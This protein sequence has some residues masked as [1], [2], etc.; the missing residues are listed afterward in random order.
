MIAAQQPYQVWIE[1][2]AKRPP[3]QNGVAVLQTAD[4]GT[5]LPTLRSPAKTL[6]MRTYPFIALP[7]ASIVLMGLQ[8]VSRSGGGKAPFRHCTQDLPQ[9]ENTSYY[10]VQYLSTVPPQS[11]L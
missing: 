9:H 4:K 7:F 3:I 2:S 1:L 10:L 5:V 6:V 11:T 8:Q